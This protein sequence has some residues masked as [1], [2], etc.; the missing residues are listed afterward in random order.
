MDKTC[1]KKD[2]HIQCNDFLF[3]LNCLNRYKWQ[4]YDTMEAFSYFDGLDAHRFH[5]SSVCVLETLS[6]PH[7]EEQYI[8]D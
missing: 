3:P 7:L 8:M 2:K 1:Y 6:E 4:A 5:Q